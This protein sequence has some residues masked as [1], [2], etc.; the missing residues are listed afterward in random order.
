MY[1]TQCLRLTVVILLCCAVT[2]QD[3]DCVIGGWGQWSVC[4]TLCGSGTRTRSRVVLIFSQ[5]AGTAC[6]TNL[7]ETQACTGTNC[8]TPVPV[9]DVNC[10]MSGWS[11]W[12]PCTVTCGGG[13]QARFRNVI[14][15]PSGSGT[16]CPASTG[17]TR[18][19]N[20]QACPVPTAAPVPTC[21]GYTGWSIWGTCDVTC[22]GGVQQRTRSVICP[23]CPDSVLCTGLAETRPCNPQSCTPVAVDCVMGN[24][25]SLHSGSPSLSVWTSCSIPC[26]STPGCGGGYQRRYR[27]IITPAQNGG[28]PCGPTEETKNG[29]N[30][31][32]CTPVNCVVSAYS[33][34]GSCDIVCGTGGKQTR[35]RNI[36]QLPLNGGTLCPVLAES[37]PCVPV[38]PLCSTNCTYGGW[39]GGP[40]SG[41]IGWSS[42]S[43]SCGTGYTF[44]Q[45]QYYT[46]GTGPSAACD[47]CT[48]PG[49]TVV[50]KNGAWWQ[51]T[52]NFNPYNPS[53]PWLPVWNGWL[54]GHF[55]PDNGTFCIHN[56]TCNTQPCSD[57]D[58]VVSDFTPWTECSQKCKYATLGP[59]GWTYGPPGSR[60]RTRYVIKAQEGNGTDCP[61]L[62]ESEVCNDAPCD[63]DCIASTW[64][65]FGSCSGTCWDP[66]PTPR[67]TRN[68]TRTIIIVKQFNGDNC[69]P[70]VDVE[71]CDVKPCNQA[72]IIGDW[73]A[74]S[75]CT[76]VCDSGVK[77]RTREVLFPAISNG[78]EVPCVLPT[79]E[80]ELC[81][82]VACRP[83]DCEVADWQP[84][85]PCLDQNGQE[86]LCASGTVTG[87]TTTRHRKVTVVPSITGLP[88][89][90]LNET[91]PCN[92]QACV[93]DC[94]P[95]TWT[96]W[97]QCSVTCGGGVITRKR[98]GDIQPTNGGA[99]CP[100]PVEEMRPCGTTA[101]NPDDCQVSSWTDWSACNELCAGGTQ[102]RTRDIT[103]QPINGVSCPPT[104]EYRI[105]NAHVC[106]QD[107]QIGGW[108]EWSMCS[109]A[110]NGGK[111]ESVGFVLQVAIAG[112]Q[113]PETVRERDCNVEPCK[114]GD[115]IT[116]GWS[117]WSMCSKA[118]EGGTQTRKRSIV[119]TPTPP[120]ECPD[121]EEVRTCNSHVCQRDCI[122]SDWSGWEACSDGC[123]GGMQRRW[124]YILQNASGSG[125]PCPTLF[126]LK[127]CNTHACAGGDCQ[128][129]PFTEWGECD[130]ACGS[131]VQTRSRL[132]RQQP[133][134]PSH[135]P[136][137]P[138]LTTKKECNVHQCPAPC[139][140]SEWSNW[141]QCSMECGGGIQ[142]RQRWVTMAP[143]GDMFCP[144]AE[145]HRQCNTQPCTDDTCL[146]SAWSNWGSCSGSCG[147]QG[148]KKRTRNVIA[149]KGVQCP[150]LEE[151][152]ECNRHPCDLDCA[153]SDWNSWSLCSSTCGGGTQERLRYVVQDRVGNGNICPI[154]IERKACSESACVAGGCVAGPWTDWTVCTSECNG[155]TQIRRRVLPANGCNGYPVEE[156]RTCNVEACTSS[157]TPVPG[158]P[159]ASS[160]SKLLPLGTVSKC[161]TITLD[162]RL[163]RIRAGDTIMWSTS[164]ANTALQSAL[165]S[166]TNQLYTA[167]NL[168]EL[169]I[170]GGTYRVCI[171][172]GS[173]EPSCQAFVV[174]DSNIDLE[175]TLE[176]GP[177]RIVTLRNDLHLHV[178]AD[179]TD[180]TAQ[181]DQAV[182]QAKLTF[183]W[184][185]FNAAAQLALDTIRNLSY[186]S[187]HI[188]PGILSPGVHTLKNTVCSSVNDICKSVTCQITVNIPPL[189]PVISLNNGTY[190][191]E[192]PVILDGRQSLDSTAANEGQTLYRWLC[193]SASNTCPPI[194]PTAWAA[195]SLYIFSSPPAET[196]LFYLEM[197]KESLVGAA[198]RTVTSAPLELV[199]VTQIQPVIPVSIA[200]FDCMPTAVVASDRFT[201]KVT[202]NSS[203]ANLAYEWQPP[204]GVEFA[205]DSTRQYI[206]VKE[207]QLAP[208]ST[209]A[210]TVKVSSSFS[211]SGLATIYITTTPQPIKG[212]CAVDPLAGVARDTLFEI[213]CSGWQCPGSVNPVAF[214][215]R[216]KE[217][218]W[219]GAG[220]HHEPR[221]S[222]VMLDGSGIVG[223]EG[224]AKCDGMEVSVP[225]MQVQVQNEGLGNEARMKE[226]LYTAVRYGNMV[227]ALRYLRLAASAGLDGVFDAQ[228]LTSTFLS[229]RQD[230]NTKEEATDMIATAFALSRRLAAVSETSAQQLLDNVNG[231]L[232][233][234][235][236]AN[237]NVARAAMVHCIAIVQ[238]AIEDLNSNLFP[239]LRSIVLNLQNRANPTLSPTDQGLEISNKD[240]GMSVMKVTSSS[241]ETKLNSLGWGVAAPFGF[242]N[243]LSGEAGYT[244]M[245]SLWGFYP[246]DMPQDTRIKTW[247]LTLH[248]SELSSDALVTD[249]S[250]KPIRITIPLKPLAE[251]VTP[252]YFDV[253]QKNWS[254]K[255]LTPVDLF[256]DAN[257]G[258][259]VM[260]FDT[261]HTTDF[262]GS[263]TSTNVTVVGGSSDDSA[264]SLVWIILAVGLVACCCCIAIVLL[265]TRRARNK[266]Q[267][268]E[269]STPS[270]TQLEVYPHDPDAANPIAALFPPPDDNVKDPPSSPRSVV[271]PS[272]ARVLEVGEE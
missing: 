116:S 21:P 2:G 23:T 233:S 177:E 42:C 130:A 38:P 211:R 94:I 3:V 131:G 153:V 139:V 184:S 14:T 118:C 216:T 101:C 239:I 152:I 87:G 119:S 76:K 154:L 75:Q 176:G 91:K 56:E 271:Y 22:G 206:T 134:S 74:W 270:E 198:E 73:S 28:T 187:L 31:Q 194:F 141:S 142:I 143:T 95:G 185:G 120:S 64:S 15:T 213:S 106:K 61:S 262:A 129:T 158:V 231:Y 225:V 32:T 234:S 4:S 160:L 17:E 241:S 47:F 123:G 218:G 219:L 157:T 224:V 90:V 236:K 166:A 207:M 179:W 114:V 163:S 272:N 36:T 161:S 1:E 260:V 202:A 265:I 59:S 199:F 255:G 111:Q 173:A 212:T 109:T 33:S 229:L 181:S 112:D 164:N 146:V 89:P 37:Q 220:Y 156:T 7:V 92:T 144:H 209:Y 66:G 86:I 52:T 97:S 12:S 113:C 162:G 256:T 148:L 228:N 77:Q 263:V 60:S 190:R 16:P 100:V 83:G 6:P 121:L 269:L 215:F 172:V 35:T 235:I 98:L 247:Y 57:I 40:I 252:V 250:T 150:V 169:A 122:T 88:C 48:F 138:E 151:E 84:W 11:L 126:E 137:P 223:L 261:T 102:F 244:I 29:C 196:L 127:S 200:C 178:N 10:V 214:R 81:N 53:T 82:T 80:E 251:E 115:C 110:C 249:F 175:V 170:Q 240:I 103:K 104:K 195:S 58:C 24:W 165:N 63:V 145:E 183:S 65:P 67:P 186:P 203:T 227:T 44:R 125:T 27:S 72:C 25:S 238:A 192:Q 5:G 117:A 105:C 243:S 204:T 230:V 254:S 69:G 79:L 149:A 78:N 197:K 124:R 155:G 30:N 205:I 26:C 136:C 132:I 189:S 46:D 9:P 191:V 267:E 96:D 210:F 49:A 253:V 180:C 159:S 50:K 232:T 62:V 133:T 51:S 85:G 245:S 258:K 93:R 257:V 70:L 19:C 188:P 107:C 208:S 8:G 55:L 193:T 20:P 18:A 171:V 99:A 237:F 13:F 147:P 68:R 182:P 221:I 268:K 226:K 174:T 54:G 168:R 71:F 45:Q 108:S 242:I 167:L 217:M 266:E 201:L 135:A 140:M 39:S 41:T 34:W 43:E 259:R 128:V 248:V 222:S 264:T 246:Y